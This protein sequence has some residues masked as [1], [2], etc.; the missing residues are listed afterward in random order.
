MEVYGFFEFGKE[1]KVG[2]SFLYMNLE[3]VPVDYD[4]FD[5]EG[6]RFARY[7]GLGRFAVGG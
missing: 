6:R 5:F 3:F 7:W 1:Y 2:F 4:Y